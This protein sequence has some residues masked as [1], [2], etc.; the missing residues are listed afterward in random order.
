[1]A[2]IVQPQRWLRQPPSLTLIDRAH[3]LAANLCGTLSF[4]G[5]YHPLNAVTGQLSTSGYGYTGI[6]RVVTPAGTGYLYG[7]SGYNSVSALSGVPEHNKRATHVVVFTRASSGAAGTLSVIQGTSSSIFGQLWLLGDGRVEARTGSP[8]NFP[9]FTTVNAAKL[10]E[11]NVAILCVD[12][13]AGTADQRLYL[14][15]VLEASTAAT[16]GGG[17]IPTGLRWGNNA[18]GT[19]L[20][21]HFAAYVGK[22]LSHDE[23]LELSRNPWQVFRPQKRVTFFLGSFGIPTLSLPG[24]QDITAVSARP[25]VTL[26][27]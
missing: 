1:M 26:S 15:G 3:P 12:G 25:R 13:N 11:I 10:S 21:H 16:T 14:N 18:V 17:Y 8:F 27:F 2:H 23:A 20:L 5:A 4:S 6:T 19:M 22:S 7:G 9:T 24:V